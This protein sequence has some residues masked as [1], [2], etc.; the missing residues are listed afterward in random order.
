VDVPEEAIPF[1]KGG[2]GGGQAALHV[3]ES[4]ADLSASALQKHLK[5][6]NYPAGKQ[7]LIRHAHKNNAPKSVI[8]MSR[9]KSYQSAADGSREPGRVT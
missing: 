4:F 7:D 5:G 8:E 3:E 9:E 2:H 6:M 1:V